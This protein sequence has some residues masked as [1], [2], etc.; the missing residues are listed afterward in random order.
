M[1]GGGGE[2]VPGEV[3]EEVPE[4]VLGEVPGERRVV[5]GETEGGSLTLRE[6][7]GIPRQG[8]HLGGMT[9][10]AGAC[11]GE[12]LMIEGTGEAPAEGGMRKMREE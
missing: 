6:R 5:T 9:G 4:E 7:K 3:L 2:I 12:G 10:E 11:Q 1:R 8:A